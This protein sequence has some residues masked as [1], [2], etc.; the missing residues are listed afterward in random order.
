MD[1]QFKIRSYGYGE[2]AQL[3]F[4][5]VSKKSATWQL[6]LWIRKSPQLVINLKAK[7]HNKGQKILSPAQVE[8][9]ITH[10]GRP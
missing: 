4:P 6:R 3:Y 5:N 10:F 8:I 1:E 9:L 7:G 2:L